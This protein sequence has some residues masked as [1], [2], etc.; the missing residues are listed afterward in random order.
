MAAVDAYSNCPCGSGQKYKWCCQKV[1]AYAERAQRMIDSGQF[2]SAI[3]VVDEGLA[4][5]P[6]NPWLLTRRAICN[7]QLN[8]PEPAKQSLRE[9]LRKQPGHLPGL[10]LLVQ[11]LMETE[12]PSAA[13]AQFQQA[14]SSRQPE[15][16][17][18]LGPVAAYIGSTLAQA[19]FPAAALK[20]LELAKR[21][22]LADDRQ[23]TSALNAVQTNPGFSVWEKNPYRLWT[24]PENVSPQ[25]RESYEQA[26]SWANEG[27]WQ[28][29]G[30]AFELLS[31]AT[32]AGAIADRNLGLCRPTTDAVDLEALC[33]RIDQAPAGD[34][35]DLVQLTWPIRNRAGLLTALKNQAVIDEGPARPFDPQETS[36]D[37]PTV[38]HFYLLDRPKVAAR[39]GLAASEIPRIEADVLI[40]HDTVALETFDDGR[41]DR[42][43]DR[44]VAMAGLN[45]PP[46]HPRTRVVDQAPKTELAM[47][48][49]WQIPSGLSET[50]AARV[51]RDI[52][53]GLINEVWPNT[54]NPALRGRSPSQAAK[55]ANAEVP[56]R[57]AVRTLEEGGDDWVDLIDWAQFRAKLQLKPEPAID[58]LQVNIEQIH[59][60][61]LSLIPVDQLD[62]DRIIAL[63][64]RSRQW[65]ARTS[66]IRAARHIADHPSLLIKGEIPPI[67][68]FG[69]LALHAAQA[70]DRS[71][72]EDW[73]RRGR[74]SHAP[75][76][77]AAHALAWEL[78]EVQILLLT[79]KPE[80]W[81][82][83]LAILLERYKSSQEATSAI[84]M[85]LVDLGLV[86]VVV[87]PD[88]PEQVGLDTRVLEYYLNRFG[89]RVT[90]A[91]GE[92][93]VA[94]AG[95]EIWTPGSGT[96]NRDKPALWLPGSGNAPAPEGKSRVLLPGQ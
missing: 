95:G 4:K 48:G 83:R 47:A 63:Y 87:D 81:V 23:T 31:P 10:Y 82:P 25:F 93:G 69:D 12:T 49:R 92:L 70:G 56:L 76:A 38:E 46:S 59:L 24:T 1:E 58:P 15:E 37:A 65:G 19:G 27:L 84:F 78:L 67:S 14:L 74:E 28:A 42:L 6:D 18:A 30:A 13:V 26:L 86:R 96:P 53:I 16:R 34:L 35:V 61:R 32:S 40:G 7:L 50:E 62:D 88:R 20:H 9:L 44:F 90:T 51:N 3:K 43:T 71:K 72:A 73:V 55:A 94:A 41:L 64:R 29:A 33:Q 68:L 8:Q 85:R 60:S 2:E 79:D 91:T 36:K 5:V 66:M 89:P 80:V 57:A 17:S 77:R 75:S 54:P 21:L 11:L 22:G 39:D 52:F 45:I